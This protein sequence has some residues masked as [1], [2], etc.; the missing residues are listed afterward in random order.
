MKDT[1]LRFKAWEGPDLTWSSGCSQEAFRQSE[2][3][4]HADDNG[5]P[6]ITSTNIQMV[7]I[8]FETRSRKCSAY[9]VWLC[10]P[11]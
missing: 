3:G 4:F 11:A 10:I 9:L 1:T 6:H 8:C 7:L 2:L 5:S